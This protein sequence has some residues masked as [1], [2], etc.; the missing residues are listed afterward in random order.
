M[1]TLKSEKNAEL[2]DWFNA[3]KRMKMF[4]R[5]PTSNRLKLLNHCFDVSA[6]ITWPNITLRVLK[7]PKCQYFVVNRANKTTLI[8]DFRSEARA[9]NYGQK[10]GHRRSQD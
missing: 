1:R 2:V 3:E 5:I 7:S 8:A 10:R 9:M 4:S 6:V